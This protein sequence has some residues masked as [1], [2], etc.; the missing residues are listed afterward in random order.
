MTSV[1][2]EYWDGRETFGACVGF[3]WAYYV[4]D[5]EDDFCVLFTRSRLVI[6]ERLPLFVDFFFS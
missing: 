3:I 6:V 1:P 4:L 5:I 2:A